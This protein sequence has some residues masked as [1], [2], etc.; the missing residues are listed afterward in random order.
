MAA[1]A[2]VTAVGCGGGGGGGGGTT[3]EIPRTLS[4]ALEGLPSSA[5]SLR[6]RARQNGVEIT[7][8]VARSVGGTYTIDVIDRTRGDF[9]VTIAAYSG[10]GITGTKISEGTVNV[11]VATPNGTITMGGNLADDEDL[12][13]AATKTE[14]TAGQTT[15]DFADLSATLGGA[16]L[17]EGEVTFTVSAVPNNLLTLT[18]SRITATGSD[19]SGEPVAATVTATYVD[20]PTVTQTVVVTVFANTGSAGGGVRGGR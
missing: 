7:R 5:K 17:A 14:L 20:K 11:P 19:Y 18:G 4:L 6:I 8:D 15:V 2:V 3:E 12:A 1:L 13:V 16:P 9:L 10:V